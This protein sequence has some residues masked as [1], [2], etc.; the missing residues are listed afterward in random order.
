MIRHSSSPYRPVV[1][2][3]AALAVLLTSFDVIPM[4][5]APSSYAVQ[6]RRGRSAPRSPRAKRPRQTVKKKSAKRPSTKRSG[7]QRR[8]ARRVRVR[9]TPMTALRPILERELGQG[10]RYAEYRSNGSV[11]VDVHVLTMDR[12]VVG[13]AVRIVKGEDRADGL[14]R[15]GEMYSRYD[16][17]SGHTVFGMVNGN[18]W[19]A[20]RN[21]SIGPCVIDGEVVELN[22]YKKWSSAFFDVG[23]TLYI[24]T[25]RIS[26]RIEWK[27]R[28]FMISSVNR[29]IDSGIVVYNSYA[30]GTVPSVHERELRSAFEEALKETSMVSDDSTEIELTRER[31]KEEISQA[32]R[33]ADVE[34][35]MVK[36]G[37]RYLRSA[38]LN[39]PIICQVLSIDSGTV[40]VPLRGAVISFPRA[41]FVSTL[42][43]PGDTISIEYSTNLHSSVR[44]MNA[45]SGTPRLV[46]NG[47]ARHE[48]FDEGSTGRRFITHNLARTAIGTDRNNTR[49]VLAAI[50][51]SQSTQGT[52]GATLQ[53]TADV[54]RL[55]GCH[56][57]MNLDGGG[58]SGMVVQRDHVFFDGI[59]PA[60]RR[61]GVGLAIVKLSH[62]L[63]GPSTS[64]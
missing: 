58:S 5:A 15:L 2:V 26:G 63:R 40:N 10:I 27:G 32:K 21:T 39:A 3:L 45:V 14:E 19:R 24:D 33:E 7:K 55:L 51:P 48:A 30:G 23:N 42:P 49:I 57:A 37:V 28:S 52:M 38:A 35:P 54:M 6:Q 47:K 16:S 61:V 9:T 50:E 62:V 56:D 29:R 13:N 44:F 17:T 41:A 53:Q 36:V 59:D 11:P 25:F 46:R 1:A 8:R 31:L 20:V 64:P 18:F 22:S 60:T 4:S 34:F 12:S 43:R